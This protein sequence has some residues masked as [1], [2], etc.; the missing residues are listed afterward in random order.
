MDPYKSLG[1]SSN[2]M[3]GDK[4]L[5]IQWY[6]PSITLQEEKLCLYFGFRFP[7]NFSLQ[8]FI[9]VRFSATKRRL[10]HNLEAVK[11]F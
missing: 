3:V 6:E 4:E 11:R 1:K 7:Y 5:D 2:F 8:H 9:Q 10:Q